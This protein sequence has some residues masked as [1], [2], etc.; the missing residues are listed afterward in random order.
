MLQLQ[1]RLYGGISYIKTYTS[2]TTSTMSGTTRYNEVLQG[3]TS[4][5]TIATSGITR[6]YDTLRG[7]TSGTR[8]YYE[9]L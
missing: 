6:Y 7:A 4:G 1:A 3:T 8:R 2:A 5:T 9:V